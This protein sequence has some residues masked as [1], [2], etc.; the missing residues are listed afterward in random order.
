MYKSSGLRRIQE[1]NA[2]RAELEA[3]K[4]KVEEFERSVSKE[5]WAWN[6]RSQQSEIEELRRQV[7]ERE[8]TIAEREATAAEQ[9]ALHQAEVTEL[10][11]RRE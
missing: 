6:D 8:A 3:E 11:E 2:L 4:T 9:A 10:E 5:A 7:A 1:V